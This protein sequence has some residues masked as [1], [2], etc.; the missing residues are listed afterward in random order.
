VDVLHSETPVAV[1]RGKRYFFVADGRGYTLAC[2]GRDDIYPRV[3]RWCDMI[4]ATLVVG[5]EVTRP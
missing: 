5:A 3:S 2:E 4:A 1:T